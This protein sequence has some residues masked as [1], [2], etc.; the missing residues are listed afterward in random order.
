MSV[1]IRENEESGISLMSYSKLN[2]GYNFNETVLMKK[3][4]RGLGCLSRSC[5]QEADIA[6]AYVY[7]VGKQIM[8]NF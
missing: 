5:M 1:L 2:I 6:F 3:R 7:R 4:S 8:Y